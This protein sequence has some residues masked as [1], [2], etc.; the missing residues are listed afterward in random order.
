MSDD[1]RVYAATILFS[2]YLGWL[3]GTRRD[4][5]RRDAIVALVMA[6]VVGIGFIAFGDGSEGVQIA[7]SS[8]LV[9]PPIA[10]GAI[11]SWVRFRLK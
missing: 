11:Q 2:L 1:C 4:D 5:D 8:L 7:A 9:G 3:G 10:I 6:F